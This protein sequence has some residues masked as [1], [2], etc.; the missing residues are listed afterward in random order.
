MDHVSTRRCIDIDTVDFLQIGF[1]SK[2]F[3]IGMVHR[4]FAGAHELE[5]TWRG[6]I[7]GHEACSLVLF[8]PESGRELKSPQRTNGT[9]LQSMDVLNGARCFCMAS[10][11]IDFNSDSSINV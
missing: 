10:S 2:F 8:V 1:V 9:E 6:N 3:E 7:D 4:D 11:M 5:Y